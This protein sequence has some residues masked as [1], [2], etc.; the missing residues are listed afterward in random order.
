[1]HKTELKMLG[2]LYGTTEPPSAA[3][4]EAL[5]LEKA[6]A[7]AIGESE[8]RHQARLHAWL[9]KNQILHFAPAN[10]GKRPEEETRRLTAV[11]FTC[12]V[13]DMWIMEPRAPY[14]A[15]V[16]ELKTQKGTVSAAQ[17]YWIEALTRRNYKALVSY[18]CE[19]SFRIVNEYLNLPHWELSL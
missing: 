13:L 8:H 10:E 11:G 2:A 7:R 17:Q 9:K 6:Q 3:E 18:S 15:L 16:L 5:Q 1:M 12:G 19:E 14:H 4:V